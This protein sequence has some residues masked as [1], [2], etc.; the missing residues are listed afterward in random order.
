MLEYEC[1]NCGWV[2]PDDELD[3]KT[4]EEKRPYGMGHAEETIVD[5]L[6]CPEC[7]SSRV[8]PIEDEDD[9]LDFEGDEDEG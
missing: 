1:L 6:L 7:G 4:H 2:G 8:D 9:D 5:E 3:Q